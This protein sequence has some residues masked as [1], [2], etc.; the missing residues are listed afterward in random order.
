MTET[1]SP[2]VTPLSSGIAPT[3]KVAYADPPYP[4]MSG[5]YVDHPDYA[6]EVDHSGLL[7][8]LDSQYDGWLLHTAATTLGHV[9]ECAQSAAVDGFR[10]MA[11]VKPFAAFKKNVRPAYAWEPILV[12]PCRTPEVAHRVV[13]RDWLWTRTEDLSLDERDFI[14]EGITMQ[15]GL[16]GV[17][18]ERVCR[19]AFEMLGMTP[20]DELVDLFPG[21]GAVTRAWENWRDELRLDFGGAA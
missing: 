8:D 11:W 21:S 2:R 9:L 12:K 10:I 1:E 6:G 19:W 15:R 16:I 17:K 3:A 18:P 4:G 13:M 20:D 7:A 5:F 14:A